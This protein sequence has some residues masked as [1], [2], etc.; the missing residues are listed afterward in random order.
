MS[1]YRPQ[2][3]A[4]KHSQII[5]RHHQ[6]RIRKKK[7]ILHILGCCNVMQFCDSQDTEQEDM[8]QFCK[9]KIMFLC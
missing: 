6:N 5:F 2:S 1:K 7:K 3:F 8:A 9:N 4:L